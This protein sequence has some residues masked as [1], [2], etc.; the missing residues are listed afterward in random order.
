[1][2]ALKESIAAAGGVTKASLVCGV[3]P[4]AIYKWI[5]ADSL[6]RTDYTGETKYAEKLAEASG[7]KFTA[8]WLLIE[9]APNKTAA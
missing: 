5:T 2:S 7:G 1:M 4:R 6:P 3:S 8:G 9:A